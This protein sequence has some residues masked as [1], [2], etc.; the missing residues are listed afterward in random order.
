MASDI[1]STSGSP[2]RWLNS[3]V[4]GQETSRETWALAARGKL[5]E[6]AGELRRAPSR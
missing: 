4:V 1:P 6:V 5:E 3:A 2:R